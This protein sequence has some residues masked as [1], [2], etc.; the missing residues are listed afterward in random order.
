MSDGATAFGVLQFGGSGILTGT[1]LNPD[2]SPALGADVT[3]LAK[4]FDEDSCSLV[5]G[6]AQRIRTDSAGKFRFTGV[7]VGSISVSAS[8]PLFATNVGAGGTLAKNSDSIDFALKL[9]NTIS[10]VLSGTVYL[11]D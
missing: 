10:G 6:I 4:V 11:P 5:S 2:N 1:V 3:L 7:N 9:V 8:H